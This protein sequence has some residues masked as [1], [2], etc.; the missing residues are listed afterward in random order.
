MVV[1][2]VSR[3]D[4]LKYVTSHAHEHPGALSP[5]MSP[6]S[7]GRQPRQSPSSHNLGAAA[8]AAAG[9]S[10]S[11]T[12]AVNGVSAGGFHATK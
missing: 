8:A 5:Q 6:T 10:G 2:V 11:G 4:L 9:S 1:G 7:G 12:P 3:I